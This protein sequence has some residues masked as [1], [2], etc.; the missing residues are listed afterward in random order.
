ML[1]KRK[2]LFLLQKLKIKIE[3]IQIKNLENLIKFCEEKKEL[4]IKYELRK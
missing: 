3:Y 2:K 4:K 1:N